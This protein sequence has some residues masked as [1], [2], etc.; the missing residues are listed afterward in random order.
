MMQAQTVTLTPAAKS[1]AA[2]LSNLLELY[3]H[4]LSAA[5]EVEIGRDGKFGYPRLAGYFD[6]PAR[7]FAFLIRVADK[8]AGFALVTR[9]SPATTDP[10]DLDV[11]E[12]FVLRRHR[13]GGVGRLAATQ[14]WDRIS[15]HWVVRVADRN[16]AALPFWR[17]VIADYSQGCATSR[18]LVDAGKCWTVFEF[19]AKGCDASA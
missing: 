1:D 14:L 9:G 12:F 2:I 4:D 15:G 17:A 19:S 6:D 13:L 5:F 11:A 7:H 3:V 18:E 10:E 8:L 16:A